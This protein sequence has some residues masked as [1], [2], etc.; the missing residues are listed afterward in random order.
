MEKVNF[1]DWKKIPN[2]ISLF[3]IIFIPIIFYLFDNVYQ[4]RWIIILVLILFSFFDNLD[5]FIAR[6]LNQ[7]TELGKVIDPLVDKFFVITIA[8]LSF[9]SKLL[10]EWFLI[11]VIARDLLIIMAGILFLKKI[12]RV[13]PSDFIGKLTAGAIGLIFLI[14]LLNFQ[15]MV[16]LYNLSLVICS[17][18]IILSL[19]NYG[20]KQIL[21]AK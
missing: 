17:F 3:R 12:K 10:P 9:Y 6:K 18:L 13:P 16:F 20:Y 21:N 14:S 11:L 15:R 4:N 5:G 19:I 8:I 2:L 1:K 7:I